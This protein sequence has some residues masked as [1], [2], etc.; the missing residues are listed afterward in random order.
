MRNI[1]SSREAILPLS[2]ENIFVQLSVVLCGA[3]PIIYGIF[4]AYPVIICVYDSL[5]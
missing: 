4:P 5:L 3:P 1:A 2:R